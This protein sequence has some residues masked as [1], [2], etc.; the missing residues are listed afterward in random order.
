[1]SQYVVFHTVV[2]QTEDGGTLVDLER[3]LCDGKPDTPHG[4]I[5]NDV[6]KGGARKSR[7]RLYSRCI[8]GAQYWGPEDEALLEQG[9]FR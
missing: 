6:V 3:M 2:R 7:P 8:C 4:H 5:W 9:R 1:M